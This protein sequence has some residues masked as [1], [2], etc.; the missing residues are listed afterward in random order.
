MKRFI[1]KFR[2]NGIFITLKK[3]K[4]VNNK[5]KTKV[6]EWLNFNKNDKKNLFKIY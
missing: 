5:K 3:R 4:N 1:L 2:K 6:K